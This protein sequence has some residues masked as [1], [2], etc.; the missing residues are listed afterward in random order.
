MRPSVHLE[1]QAFQE[2]EKLH[3]DHKDYGVDKRPS[4]CLVAR[5][6]RSAEARALGKEIVE[7][8]YR[9]KMSVPRG[10]ESSTTAMRSG[11]VRSEDKESDI[12]P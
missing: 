9:A 4:T 7:P 11:V 3:A 1:G 10:P 12:R 5:L 8:H 2:D 6:F